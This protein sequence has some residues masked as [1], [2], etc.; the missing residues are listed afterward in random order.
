MEEAFYKPDLGAMRGAVGADGLALVTASTNDDQ[1][2]PHFN[3]RHGAVRNLFKP[4]L[5]KEIGVSL[6]QRLCE[7][8]SPA[9]FES[10]KD[11]EEDD[12]KKMIE[13]VRS[14][15][16][17]TPG[18]DLLNV[19]PWVG[20]LLDDAGI[21]FLTDVGAE[22][23]HDEHRGAF[24]T[25]TFLERPELFAKAANRRRST[26]SK[27]KKRY[28][29]FRAS[30][31]LD[32]V[33]IATL[34]R[35]WGEQISRSCSE[36]FIEQR[37]GPN[38]HVW[39]IDEP[40]Q[41]GVIVDRATQRK[42]KGQYDD[43]EKLATKV[44]RDEKTDIAFYD[45][46]TQTLWVFA[47]KTMVP[48][49]AQLLGEFLFGDKDLFDQRLTLDLRFALSPDL[50]VKLDA[51]ASGRVIA[52]RMKSRTIH[53]NDGTNS[54]LNHY[55][56]A[57]SVCVSE[58]NPVKQGEFRGATVDNIILEVELLNSTRPIFERIGITG[59]SV[60]SGLHVT[61]EELKK[62]LS[63]LGLLNGSPNE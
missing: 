26:N 5:L 13:T 48:F 8:L 11:F 16:A 53:T 18:Q 20:T 50:K 56:N 3:G 30:K 10:I 41:I 38:S 32:R 17:P 28:A 40:G 6:F 15:T 14:D 2:V 52:V 60:Q 36:Y 62:L 61:D 25:R 55:Q 35:E 27:A 1:V 46:G 9:L 37:C 54:E 44:F 43:E 34:D 51:C 4:A 22:M 19:L 33:P 39:L 42:S 45:K 24:V 49:Y 63:D 12:A 57:K 31:P 29:L 21:E 59:D 47:A 23:E 58:E 7:K